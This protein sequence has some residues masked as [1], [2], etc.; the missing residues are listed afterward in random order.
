M[1]GP[2]EPH[3]GPERVEPAAARPRQ[4]QPAQTLLSGLESAQGTARQLFVTQVG[5]PYRSA[6]IQY[7]LLW[8]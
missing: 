6:R 7:R 1:T 8:K 3:L 5:L 4:A 2:G